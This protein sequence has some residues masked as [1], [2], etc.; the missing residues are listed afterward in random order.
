MLKVKIRKIGNSL[1]AILP[2]ESLNSHQLEEGDELLISIDSDGIKLTP[3][4]PDFE[5][6]V[7]AAKVGMRRYRNALKELAK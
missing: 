2:A 1:G 7:E 6:S 4:D 3:Y 5:A